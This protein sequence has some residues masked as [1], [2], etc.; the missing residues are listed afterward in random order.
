MR[1]QVH[2]HG[3]I[4]LIES[5]VALA[6]LMVGVLALLR[7]NAS[8]LQTSMQSRY[9]V[10]AANFAEELASLAQVDRDNIACYVTTDGIA[11]DCASAL[12]QGHVT[13]WLTRAFAVLPESKSMP[14]AVEYDAATGTFLVTMRWQRLPEPTAHQFVARTSI[15]LGP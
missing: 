4:S 6:V 5:L 13:D 11:P 14:P 8:M 7:L 1:T 10:E 9:R 15:Y 3:G 2:R 12:A